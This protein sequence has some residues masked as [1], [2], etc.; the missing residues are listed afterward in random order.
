[1]IRLAGLVKQFKKVRVLDALDLNI[2]QGERIALVLLDL[3][4]RGL[5]ALL[6]ELARV[7]AHGF[8]DT[9]LERAKKLRPDGTEASTWA[10]G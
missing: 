10:A 5:D 4:D 8:T 9:E 7:D 3:V 1:M 6:V 2:E